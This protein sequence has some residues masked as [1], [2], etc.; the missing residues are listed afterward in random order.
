MMS[1]KNNT[2]KGQV[3][4]REVADLY[5][6]LNFKV[7]HNIELYG[8]QVD[9][10][11][12]KMIDGVGEIK[13]IVECKYLEKGTVSNQQVQDFVSTMCALKQREQSLIG[14]LITNTDFSV[15]AKSVS[16]NITL[17]TLEQL[18]KD[19]FNFRHS[20]LDIIKDFEKRD[21][22]SEFI[23]LE[24]VIDTRSEKVRLYSPLFNAFYGIKQF[25]LI[26]KI[27]NIKCAE[28]ERISFISIL[29]DYGS[30]KTTLLQRLNYLFSKQYIDG[31]EFETHLA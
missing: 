31:G 20:F 2:E 19:I 9:I 1:Y 14:V 28:W 12:R 15:N 6:A 23:P 21:I 18:E 10:Y 7:E 30:G 17:L 26:D 25:D 8:Q 22:F 3:F 29:A 24:G 11:A 13:L 5:E 16:E 27:E 4:E